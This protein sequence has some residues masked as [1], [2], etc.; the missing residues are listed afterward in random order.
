[1]ARKTIPVY[2]DDVR[3]SELLTF[4]DS[5]KGNLSRSAYVLY[6]LYNIKNNKI[7]VPIN[8]QPKIKEKS[9]IEII[10]KPE[11]TIN[12]KTERSFLKNIKKG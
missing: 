12:K 9:E 7:V 4:I 1:M 6:T 11:K 3:D 2:Y 5:I 10:E 8:D